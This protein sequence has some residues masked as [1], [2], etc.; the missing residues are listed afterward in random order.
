MRLTDVKKLAAKQ[1]SRTRRRAAN[2]DIALYDRSFAMKVNP[3]S[4]DTTALPRD[5]DNRTDVLNLT[6][7]EVI[8]SVLNPERKFRVKNETRLNP[9]LVPDEVAEVWRQK[10]QASRVSN[11]RALNHQDKK[12]TM[13]DIF[14]ALDRSKRELYQWIEMD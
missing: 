10:I 2:R 3:F 6:E 9:D 5:I 11:A 1:T 14:G 4:S 13:R 8:D 12:Q 7:D